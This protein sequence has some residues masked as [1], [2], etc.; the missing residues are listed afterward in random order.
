MFVLQFSVGE[1]AL[2][3]VLANEVG[4]RA[5]LVARGVAAGPGE[6]HG[7]PHGVGGHLE[8]DDAGLVAVTAGDALRQRRPAEPRLHALHHGLV[9][10]EAAHHVLVAQREAV[11]LP[12][13]AI[14]HHVAAGML[15]V[16]SN[17]V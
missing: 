4:E 15:L 8:A 17:H 1:V 10:V 13:M 7:V 9:G 14:A 12:E 5:C 2:G 3:D 16:P 11:A 6:G